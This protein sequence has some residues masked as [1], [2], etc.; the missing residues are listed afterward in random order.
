MVIIMLSW[1][2]YFDCNLH[3]LVEMGNDDCSVSLRFNSRGRSFSLRERG[4]TSFRRC[5]LVWPNRS[6]ADSVWCDNAGILAA[7]LDLGSATCCHVTHVRCRPEEPRR[8]MRWVRSRNSGLAT[9]SYCAPAEERHMRTRLDPFGWAA[10]IGLVR[11]TG[12]E[13]AIRECRARAGSSSS[14]QK[15]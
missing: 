14:T 7:S 13:G 15:G 6:L 12:P 11:Y 10:N 3:S 5:A 2:F 9:R 4:V 1:P 8:R